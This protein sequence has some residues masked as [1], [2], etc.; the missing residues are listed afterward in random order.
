MLSSEM[1]PRK[2]HSVWIFCKLYLKTSFLSLPG[3]SMASEVSFIERTC[4][5]CHRTSTEQDCLVARRR[6]RIAFA[7]TT[8]AN[9][10]ASSPR[11]PVPNGRR[12]TDGDDSRCR[13]SNRNHSN[14]SPFRWPSWRTRTTT[15]VV[16]QHRKRPL[17]GARRRSGSGRA[18]AAVTLASYRR[19]RRL[20]RPGKHKSGRCDSQIS[21]SADINSNNNQ[22]NN[23]NHECFQ[24]RNTKQIRTFNDN[25]FDNTNPN[26]K[27]SATANAPRQRGGGS[28]GD[29]LDCQQSRRRRQQQQQQATTT[30]TTT[31]TECCHTTT[32]QQQPQLHREQTPP[33][34]AYYQNERHRPTTTTPFR[35]LLAAIFVLL[36]SSSSSSSSHLAN[37]RSE[38][39][40]KSDSGSPDR[41]GDNGEGTRSV[42][43]T[44]RRSTR[45]SSVGMQRMVRLFLPALL[46]V[47]MFTFLHGGEFLFWGVFP[48][49]VWGLEGLERRCDT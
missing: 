44:S 17:P 38:R 43:G 20:G 16:P 8:N 42:E 27:T 35:R 24:S 12:R 28:G 25:S 21:N 23:N 45:P 22:N 47:N 49:M 29:K 18:V 19:R 46:I 48:W 5:R 40:G 32:N 3:H 34:S 30:S 11:Q 41:R 15:V 7:N 4:Q 31:T 39:I 14:N 1:F 26:V 6:R 10:N 37:R 13:I 9:A 36:S 33:V 2:K